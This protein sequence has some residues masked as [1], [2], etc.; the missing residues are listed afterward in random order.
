[1]SVILQTRKIDEDEKKELI[2]KALSD[3]YSRIIL[4][5]TIDSAKSALELS[6]LTKI[7]ISTVYR[8]LQELHDKKLLAISGSIN[9]DGKKFFL[10]KSKIRG[11]TTSYEGGILNVSILPNK[12]VNVSLQRST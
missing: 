11:I 6:A 4:E 12:T 1:M 9:K 7:P 3:K 10:Y 5:N 2:L 8:R